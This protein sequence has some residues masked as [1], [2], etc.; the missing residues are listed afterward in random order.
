MTQAL[1]QLVSGLRLEKLE[2]NLFRGATGDTLV[3]RVYGGKVLGEALEAAQLTVED[4]PAHSL[5]AYFLREADAFHPVIYTVERSRDGRS[6][7]ARRVTAIQHGQPIFTME[8]SFHRPEEGIDYQGKMPDVPPPESVAPVQWDWTSF[9]RLPPRHQRMMTIAAPFDL[10]QID[11]AN[12]SKDALGN[13]IRRSWV[14]TSEALPDEPDMHRAVLAYL[15]DYGLIWTLLGHH[16]FSLG[17]QKLV[18]ASL[19]HAMWFHRPFRV[20]EW[21]LY[22]CEGVASTGAR[23]LARGAFYTREGELV[24]SVAQEGLMRVLR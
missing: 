21:L 2:E 17:N 3:K 10:R 19:D 4:R 6:F 16:G 11:G 22:H 7:S 9:D 18:I 24:V 23:G 12:G 5:H 8:A 20:D 15:S 1:Q 13:P 14:K